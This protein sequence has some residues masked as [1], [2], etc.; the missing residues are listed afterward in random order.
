MSNMLIVTYNMNHLPD[1]HEVASYFDTTCKAIDYSDLFNIIP[2]YEYL[3]PSVKYKLDKKLL[4]SAAKLKAIS[5]PSTGTDHIDFATCA[6][7]GIK[8][9]SMKNDIELLSYIKCYANVSIRIFACFGREVGRF[10]ILRTGTSGKDPWYRW[11][12]QTGQDDG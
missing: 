12:W 6:E 9:F 1:F 8:V 11:F 7:L 4:M 5:T 3:I 10:R 2:D